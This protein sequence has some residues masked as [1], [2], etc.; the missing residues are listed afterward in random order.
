MQLYEIN[1]QIAQL[2]EMLESGEIDQQAYDDTV[3]ALGADIAVDDVVK[4]IRNKSAEA[5]AFKAE[6]D[7]LTEKRKRAEAAV[8]G[9]KNVLVTYLNATGQKNCKTELFSISK[10]TSKSV[11]IV[12]E[13]AIPATYLIPQPAK[14]DKKA[15]LAKLKAGEQ[16][17]GATL[18]VSE[19]VTIK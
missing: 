16:V 5:E 18:E 10:G 14:L 19:F 12:D 1:G 2:A 6:A 8:D 15:I 7:R 4:A 11:A 13:T 3:E 9:L 17:Q